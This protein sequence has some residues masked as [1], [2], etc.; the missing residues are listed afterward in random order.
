MKFCGS[1]SDISASNIP[2]SCDVV[3][4]MCFLSPKIL[5][6][7]IF[8]SQVTYCD[9]FSEVLSDSFPAT[10][11]IRLARS[12]DA[13]FRLMVKVLELWSSSCTPCSGFVCLVGL[14]VEP[15]MLGGT[16]CVMALAINEPTR[17]VVV[18]I[19]DR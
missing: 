8:C 6:F 12:N 13:F 11:N 3:K 18:D 1:T 16:V 10:A 9:M 5:L 4:F 14:W 7:E 17:V 15:L 2:Q 19:L